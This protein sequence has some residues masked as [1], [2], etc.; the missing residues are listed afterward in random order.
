MAIEEIKKNECFYNH[1]ILTAKS[2]NKSP[3]KFKTWTTILLI[4]ILVIGS[5]FFIEDGKFGLNEGSIKTKNIEILYSNVGLV[6]PL[7][8]L[9]RN[10]GTINLHKIGKT[11]EVT[12]HIPKYIAEVE[13]RL[14]SDRNL[15]IPQMTEVS[16]YDPHP[17]RRKEM[18]LSTGTDLIYPVVDIVI[19][20]G[21][22]AV[23]EFE[24]RLNGMA[25][26]GGPFH[27]KERPLIKEMVI[28]ADKLEYWEN[29]IYLKSGSGVSLHRFYLRLHIPV[30]A[31]K[32][33]HTF[34]LLSED[35]SGHIS[36]YA[37]TKEGSHE[38]VTA[39]VPQKEN[40]VENPPEQFMDKE[41]SRD[42]LIK[43]IE[44]TTG[45]TLR[46]QNTNPMSPTFGG[47]FLFY[48][49]DARTYRTSYWMWGWGPSVKLLL[50]AAKISE[51]AGQ[52]TSELLRKTAKE[53]G[54]AS[55][56]MQVNEKG[57]PADGLGIAS[58]TRGFATGDEYKNGYR[59]CV[60]ATDALFLAGWA[61]MPLYEETGDEKYLVAIEKLTGSTEK[62]MDQ[63]DLLPWIYFYE[64]DSWSDYVLNESGY[65]VKG[66]S[67]AFRLTG[68]ERYRAAGIQLM[69]QHLKKFQRDDG[70]WERLWN[71]KTQTARPSIFH[72]RAQGWA[73]EGLLSAA[74][75]KSEGKYLGLAEQM[76]ETVIKWQHQ[77]GY[78][79]HDFKSPANEVG[80]SEKGTALW[81]FLLY[82]LYH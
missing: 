24:G 48:D 9:D 73:M 19:E 15:K 5:H 26:V 44:E 72:T 10:E 54:Q 14:E 11:L 37:L 47:P 28:S 53:M 34:R 78:W 13:V 81:S 35:W 25:V 32:V 68:D 77:S 67:E 76:A 6:S 50:E 80:I 29:S 64:L 12:A 55:L 62:L 56:K 22:E 30:I 71:Y 65:G 51:V 74:E 70:L 21:M 57:S 23:A 3:M 31:G 16:P 66:L 52:Y 7:I 46:S 63:G 43:A 4:S 75:L 33:E 36:I 58:W 39:I 1:H 61:W 17:V 8:L 41:L 79:T 45:F 49:L 59:I 60:T 38:L 82:R 2:I 40:K 27:Q 42:R 20:P 69:E 18:N